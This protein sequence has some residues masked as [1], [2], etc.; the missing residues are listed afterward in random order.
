MSDH[1]VCDELKK[2][3]ESINDNK[4]KGL[5]KCDSQ[6]AICINVDFISVGQNMR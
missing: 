2:S 6:K 3:I 5:A 1:F 4:G